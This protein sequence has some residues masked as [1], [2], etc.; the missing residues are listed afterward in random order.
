[1]IKRSTLI[2]LLAG[3]ILP[4]ISRAQSSP[5]PQA[6]TAT[7]PQTATQ[8]ENQTEVNAPA[9]APSE[10]A[11]ADAMPAGTALTPAIINIAVLNE[12][13]NKLDALCSIW[14]LGCYTGAGDT[15]LQ[16]SGGI[17]TKLA[18]A[19]IGFLALS[20]S[21]FEANLTH[22]DGMPHPTQATQQFAGQK[23]TWVAAPFSLYVT[24]NIPS[25]NM[26]FTI[27]GA[28]V[29]SNYAFIEGP[30]TSRV[31]MLN[32]HQT[33]FKGKFEYIV[34]YQQG[35][36][37]VADNYIGGS[38]GA[39][40]LGVKAVI[41]YN[42][43][44][45]VSIYTTP[46]L[47]LKYH[48]TDKIY[49]T[50]MAQRS[51][52]PDTGIWGMK[53]RDI[54]GFRFAP[55]GDRVL[56]MPEI[57]YKVDP[58]PGKKMTFFRATGFYNTSHFLDYSTPT[59]FVQGVEAI[60]YG[61]Y[62]KLAP[63]LTGLTTL[64]TSIPPA[65]Q[66]LYGSAGTGVAP[67]TGNNHELM[68]NSGFSLTLDR[69]LTQ[70]DKFLSYRGLYLNLIGQYAAPH[71]NTYQQ[72]Y[73]VALYSLGLLKS[74]PLDMMVINANRTQ[75]SRTAL[76]TLQSLPT[77]ACPYAVTAAALP[78]AMGGQGQALPAGVTGNMVCNGTLDAIL[79]TGTAYQTAALNSTTQAL[80]AINYQIGQKTFDDTTEISGTYSYHVMHGLYFNTNWG[81]T[82]H[83]AFAPAQHFHSSPVTALFS[84]TIAY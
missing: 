74:R 52:D 62:G 59:S 61:M 53:A 41:P 58:A 37:T 50:V 80:Q 79:G 28:S 75:Y 55:K 46:A 40:I 84:I 54:A 13:F 82:R 10:Q 24:Y 70:T 77:L 21:L 35:D 33:L 81:Y 36:T 68:V 4:A 3:L 17:R 15:L 47:T 19:N 9:G 11:A 48:F 22:M 83:P 51:T 2:L 18:K 16:D 64:P 43:G 42:L 7:A 60:N 39:G 30:N 67:I 26:Q 49:A 69:Q 31:S 65:A 23:P 14:E 66:S 12:K 38:V 44:Q 1:M 45:S 34:G 71:A 27:G 20:I 76:N 73:Q 78:V 56:Y 25:K 32:L 63:V 72:Y 6:A 5:A 57:G 29:Q 8:K